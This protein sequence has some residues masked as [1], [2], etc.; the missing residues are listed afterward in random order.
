[1]VKSMKPNKQRKSQANAPSHTKRKRAR[2]RLQLSTPDARLAGI[3]NITVRVGDSVR[4]VRAT[5]P[6]VGSA[7]VVRGIERKP[8]RARSSESTASMVASSSK[9]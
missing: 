5:A 2:A 1:M 6:M 8:R 7:S 4:V 3:R 9:G